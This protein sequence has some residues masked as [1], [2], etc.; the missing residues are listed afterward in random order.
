MQEQ[1]ALADGEFRFGPDAEELWRFVFE[2]V[3]M[4]GGQVLVRRPGLTRMTDELP[5]VFANRTAEMAAP[6]FRRTAFRIARR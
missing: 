1:S 4:I 5:F 6:Q 2:A 3:V